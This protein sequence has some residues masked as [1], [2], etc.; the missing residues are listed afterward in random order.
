M[1]MQLFMPNSVLTNKCVNESFDN[2]QAY[3]VVQFI[4]YIKKIKL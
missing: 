2:H 1:Y 3:T 4:I